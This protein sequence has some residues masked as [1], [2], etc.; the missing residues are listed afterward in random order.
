MPELSSV[1][2]VALSVTDLARSRDWYGR[3]L[4]FRVVRSASVAGVSFCVMRPSRSG[5][6]LTLYKHAANDGEAFDESRTGLDH[7]S[8]AVT[9]RQALEVWTRHLEDLGVR[10]SPV[11]EDPYGAV[12][13][14]RDPDNIQLELVVAV[15]TDAE[16]AS[17]DSTDPAEPARTD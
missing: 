7:L 12:L 15:P 14:L 1:H 17:V 11:A 9:D 5:L 8:L 3:V 13:V 16:A 6:W 10:H 4:G 2:H